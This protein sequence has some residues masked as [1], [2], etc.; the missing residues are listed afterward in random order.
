MLDALGLARKAANSAISSGLPYRLIA[1]YVKAIAEAGN[2]A[3]A[4]NK[5]RQSQRLLLFMPNCCN[6]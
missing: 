3:E 1:K 6:F 5:V 2:V 4:S